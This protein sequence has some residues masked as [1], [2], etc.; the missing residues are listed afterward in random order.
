MK[1][2][3]ESLAGNVGNDLHSVEQSRGQFEVMHGARLPKICRKEKM[4]K[5]AIRKRVDSIT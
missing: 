2:Q 3:I 4:L 1:R 5:C